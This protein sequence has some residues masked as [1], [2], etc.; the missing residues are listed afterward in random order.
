MGLLLPGCGAKGSLAAAV[1]FD[2]R[3]DWHAEVTS[4]TLKRRKA[5]VG[6]AI[7]HPLHRVPMRP[8]PFRRRFLGEAEIL[9]RCS[10]PS[11]ERG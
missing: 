10:R 6:R 11:S 2:E 9:A 3:A 4:E 5:R 8:G 7:L 1:L